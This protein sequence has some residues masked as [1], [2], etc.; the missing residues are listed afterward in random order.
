MFVLQVLGG[1]EDHEGN[2]GQLWPKRCV[3]GV[4]P[5]VF[6]QASVFMIDPLEPILSFLL[7]VLKQTRLMISSNDNE[8]V[9][10]IL[11]ETAN[12]AGNLRTLLP[13]WGVQLLNC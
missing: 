3:S 9:G 7:K 8:Y 13:K 4:N 1:V 2:V 5:E 12:R 11:L 10:S 6:P